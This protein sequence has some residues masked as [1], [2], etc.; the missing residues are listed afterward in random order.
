M[1]QEKQLFSTK[2]AAEYLGMTR[3]GLWYHIQKKHIFPWKVGQSL[4]FTKAQLDEFNASR[5][6]PGRPKS[7]QEED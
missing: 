6:P 5:R 3:G 2:K 4:V 7:T 1:E